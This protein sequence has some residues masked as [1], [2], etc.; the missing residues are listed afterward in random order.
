[1]IILKSV[2]KIYPG[3]SVALK[4]V[5]VHIKPKE[6]VSIVGRSGTGKTTLVRILTAEEPPTQGTV[7][8]GGGDITHIK[9]S[10]VPILRRQIGVVFQDFKLLEKKTVFENIA[11]ALQA[12][13]TSWRRSREIIPQVLKIVGLSGKE[14][15]YP[16]QLSGGEQQRVAIAR[17]LVHRPKILLADEPTGN[18]DSIN[19]QEI[20]DLLLKINEFGTTVL[21]VS[22]D[23]E[24]VNYI[25]KRVITLDYGQ[26][27]SDQKHGKYLI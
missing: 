14:H 2:S 20:V 18:L 1:M 16:V 21:L 26:I 11:F 6:F 15:R 19:T 22:H 9:R 4:G 17:A 5:N 23:R 27:I 10:E 25:N 3:N 13:G 7:I 8:I 12:C 24:V